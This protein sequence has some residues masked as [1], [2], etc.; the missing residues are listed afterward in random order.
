M[1]QDKSYGIL[2]CKVID[3]N[4]GKR[5]TTHFH[6]HATAEDMHF[7]ISVNIKSQVEPCEVLYYIDEDFQNELTKKLTDFPMGFSAI[8]S[9]IKREYGLDYL[10]GSIFNLDKL[11]PLPAQLPGP[12]NDL[13][14]KISGIV[15]N[16]I[17]NQNSLLYAFGRRWGPEGSRDEYFDFSPGD[18]IHDVHMNQGNT[19]YFERENDTWQDGALIFHFPSESKWIALFFAFQAQF[20][21]IKSQRIQGLSI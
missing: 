15:E 8:G 1:D 3:T 21:N 19:G 16:T 2:K 7:R 11:Q 6:M 12:D 17:K 9:N 4:Q 20:I 5:N 13:R 14:E 18:G 10:R